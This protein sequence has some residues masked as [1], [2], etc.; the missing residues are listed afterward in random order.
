[1]QFQ[2][3]PQFFTATI[4]EWRHLLR[5]DVYK[6]IVLDS[7]RFLVTDNRVAIYAFVIMPNHIH[8]I[9]QMR[10]KQVQH[11]VQQSFLKFTAQQIKFHLKANH[12][13][14]LEDFRV[15]AADRDCQIWERNP[16][17]IDLFTQPVFM[18]KLE[19]VHNNP[20]QPKWNLAIHPEEYEW[21]SARFYLT[22]NRNFDFLRHYTDGS[23]K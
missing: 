3:H 7:M 14:L 1:M 6:G 18:Q 21:S 5:S 9:W 10:N 12:P 2:H 20:I 4:L 16:L 11:K 17:S 15:N 23:A 19:Y 13:N 8:I 22:G